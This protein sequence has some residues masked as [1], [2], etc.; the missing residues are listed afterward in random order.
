MH[1]AIPL[2]HLDLILT[3]L[4]PSA[5]AAEVAERL[6]DHFAFLGSITVTIADGMAHISGPDAPAA[7]HEEAARLAARAARR[8]TEGDFA[9]ATELYQRVLALAPS[10]PGAHR[11]LAMCLMETGRL[12]AAKDTLIDALKLAPA[13]AWS[14][15]VLGNVYA[16]LEQP[17]RARAFYQ[18][19]LDLKPGDAWALHGLA[20]AEM[21]LGD[22]P[23]ARTHF[24]EATRLHPAFPNAWHGLALTELRSDHPARADAALRGLFT[25]ARPADAR[26]QPLFAEARRL[27]LDVQTTL[28]TRLESEAFKTTQA[29]RSEVEHLSGFPVEFTSEKLPGTLAGQARIAWK[30][31][32][33][34]HR[35]AIRL[36]YA[37]PI[38][39]HNTYNATS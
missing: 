18:R 2:S 12:D 27:F 4:A 1:L 23:A 8:V 10:H 26:S 21:R 29:L 11:D 32:L 6:R 38:L 25:H 22:T 7:K 17:D 20:V 3:G 33:A 9:R 28:A 31:R 19:A 14:F 5:P 16:R 15:V 36:E 13:D 24:T 35:I 39:L 34:R 37:P 30:H